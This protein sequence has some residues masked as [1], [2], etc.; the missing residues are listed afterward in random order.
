MAGIKYIGPK[1]VKHDNVAG[2]STIWAGTGDVQEV[3][4]AAV[5]LLLKHPTVWELAAAPG[6]AAVPDENDDITRPVL[7]TRVEEGEGSVFRIRDPESDEVIDLARMTDAE[8]KSFA[9]VNGIKADLR[10]RN[11]ELRAAVM[12]SAITPQEA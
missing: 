12:A 4:D 8:I 6:G 10:K 3:P 11:D 1:L 7:F 9:R 5:P 2:T